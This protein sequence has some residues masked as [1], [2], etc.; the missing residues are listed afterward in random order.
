MR[1]DGAPS[2]RTGAEERKSRNLAR[3]PVVLTTGTNA[4]AGGCDLVV[5][6]TAVRVADE[7]RLTAP[8]RAWEA[9]HGA[10]W[11]FDVRDGGFAGDRG[12]AAVIHEVAPR[13][14]FG[15]GKAP[16]RQTRWRF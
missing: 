11:H 9:E 8:A 2:F 12:N 5:E 15:F 4:L 14:A 3:N 16:Y 7:A 10:G 13:T 1:P 6:G